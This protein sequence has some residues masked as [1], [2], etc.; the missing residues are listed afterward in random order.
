MMAVMPLFGHP[1][2]DAPQS[3]GDSALAY[4]SADN[5]CGGCGRLPHEGCTCTP[6]LMD[7]L[8][9]RRARRVARHRGVERRVAA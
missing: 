9:A 2:R 7:V 4:W 5:E 1:F 3:T 6:Q 8:G